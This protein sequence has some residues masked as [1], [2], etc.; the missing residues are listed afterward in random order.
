MFGSPPLAAFPSS[1]HDT[2]TMYSQYAPTAPYIPECPCSDPCA[3]PPIWASL[4]QRTAVEDRL[5][6]ETLSP[7]A[8]VLLALRNVKP[9][10]ARALTAGLSAVPPDIG[11]RVRTLEYID[12]GGLGVSGRTL[13]YTDD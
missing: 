13:E 1:Q 9:S 6:A 2:K 4:R 8:A 7:G 12:A 5:D 11:V 3:G 10:A